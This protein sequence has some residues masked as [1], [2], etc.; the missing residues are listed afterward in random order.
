[1]G[2]GFDTFMQNPYWKRIYKNAPSENLEQYFWIRFDHS[3]FVQGADHRG[4][5]ADERLQDIALNK[6]DIQYIQ[7]IT[8]SGNARVFYKVFIE[9]LAGEYEGRSIRAS[10]FQVEEWNPNYKEKMAE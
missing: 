5:D 10:V 8:R 7:S 6:E 3:G 1:M 4:K 2:K 9:K